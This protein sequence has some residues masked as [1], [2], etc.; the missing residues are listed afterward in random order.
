[1]NHV[2]VTVLAEIRIVLTAIAHQLLEA[3]NQ[4]TDSTDPKTEKV[5]V[6]AMI[7]AEIPI[8]H[9]E[10]DRAIHV[11]IIQKTDLNDL[12]TEKVHAS[13]TIHAEIRDVH[14][15][16]NLIH[17]EI[18]QKTDIINQKA[19]Q[20]SDLMKDLHAHRVVDTTKVLAISREEPVLPAERKHTIQQPE[21][22]AVDC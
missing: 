15:E 14:L 2:L 13:E 22:T 5:H 16:T 21:L 1:M 3:S 12:T 17:A 9:L 4:K 8:V 7:H 6:S 19:N 20:I 10:T 11:E 18:N